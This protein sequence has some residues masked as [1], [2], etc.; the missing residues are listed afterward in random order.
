L[1]KI[2]ILTAGLISPNSYA[3]LHPIIASKKKLIKYNINIEIFYKIEPKIYDCNV[4]IIESKF[5]SKLWSNKKEKIFKELENFNSRIDKLCF[6]S[7]G[8]SSTFDHAM[9]LPYIDFYFKNQILD[10]KK[11]YL[12]S[13]YGNRYYSNYYFNHN[14]VVDESPVYSKPV[15][16]IKDLVK[17]KLGWN[18]SLVNWSLYSPIKLKINSKFNFLFSMNNLGK[19]IPPKKYRRIPVSI[20]F[21]TNYK[22][23]S[24]SYQ[25]EYIKSSVKLKYSTNKI[26]RINYFKELMNTK[27]VISPFGLGEITLKDFEVFL[28][29]GLLVKPTMKHMITWPNLFIE[30]E[31][32]ISCSLDLNDLNDKIEYCLDNYNSLIQIAENGQELYKSYN[33][34]NKNNYKF[35]DYFSNIMKF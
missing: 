31:T 4:L 1:K 20:R 17:I 29:G 10:N 13:F 28:T 6:Y 22:Y 35:C 26:N 18:S 9:M 23:K 15:E 27:V 25:R 21:N 24:V 7:I 34:Y 32:Y 2:N 11:L 8:D 5:Y 30:D 33:I 14:K 19:F 12:N 3:F 16:D